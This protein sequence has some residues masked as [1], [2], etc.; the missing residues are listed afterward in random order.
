MVECGK[1]VYPWPGLAPGRRVR[2]VAGSLAGVTGTL[3]RKSGKRYL[4]VGVE[5]IGQSVAV[6]LDKEVNLVS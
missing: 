4:A 3:R 5:L 1:A 2:V 6:E